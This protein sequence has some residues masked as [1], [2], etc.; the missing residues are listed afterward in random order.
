MKSEKITTIGITSFNRMKYFR[1]L[2][3]SLECLPR[4]KYEIIVVDNCSTEVG[5]QDYILDLRAKKKID[6]AI[7]RS[8]KDRNW[9][10]DEYVAKN[11][12]IQYA[13]TDTIIFLQDDLQFIGSHNILESL[14]KEFLQL[15]FPCLEMN[16]IRTCSNQDRYRSNRN[17][18]S[19]AGN[20]YWASDDN[21]FQ[22]MGL[23]DARV[24][25]ELGEYPVD[26]PVEKEYW[27]RSED[28]Y[29]ARFKEKFPNTQINVSCHI[30]LFLPVWNDPRGGYAFIRGNK[31]YGEYSDPIDTT[32]L[33]YDHLT[34]KE[35][36]SLTDKKAACSFVDVAKPLGWNYRKT[37]DGDQFK[38]SQNEIVKNEE[39]CPF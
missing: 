28:F 38:Y 7:I 27:G 2:M 25:S 10:N 4:E 6:A 16:G 31:R 11:L 26:W 22:T 23:F 3:K 15:P 24:F 19:N 5:L 30:P 13:K 21:H 33:Y 17:F 39:G 34:E 1:A 29:D 20:R 36:K 18:S 8:P 35:Y 37:Q 9:I 12:I 14:V 32:G